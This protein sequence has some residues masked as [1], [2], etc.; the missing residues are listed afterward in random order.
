MPDDPSPSPAP[1]LDAHLRETLDLLAELV[2]RV[3]DRVDSQTEALGGL[4]RRPRKPARPPSPPR[5]RLIPRS[6]ATS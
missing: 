6:T 3:S 1:P 5:R 2:A 4:A